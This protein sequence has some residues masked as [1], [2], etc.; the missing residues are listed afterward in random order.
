VSISWDDPIAASLLQSGFFMVISLFSHGNALDIT[1]YC[2][3]V[4]K[5]NF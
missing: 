5:V 4:E 3:I 2:L 1:G